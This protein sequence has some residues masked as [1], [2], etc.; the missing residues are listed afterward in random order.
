MRGRTWIPLTVV[1]VR[2]VA[3]ERGTRLVQTATDL[4]EIILDCFQRYQHELHGEQAPVRGTGKPV[5]MHGGP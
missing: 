4:R 1:E 2:K 5:A 3:A